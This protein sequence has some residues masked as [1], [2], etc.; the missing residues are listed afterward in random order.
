MSSGPDE[1][2]RNEL[3]VA[4]GAEQSATTSLRVRWQN[5][6]SHLHEL[7]LQ[8]QLMSVGPTANAGTNAPDTKAKPCQ[9]C[10]LPASASNEVALDHAVL[11]RESNSGVCER[12][13]AFTVFV[14]G[15]G[16]I[17]G[18]LCVERALRHV[19][20]GLELCPL[21]IVLDDRPAQALD[22][23]SYMRLAHAITPPNRL[24]NL[25]TLWRRLN[26][27][28]EA[29]YGLTSSGVPET[30]HSSN[31]CGNTT[32]S[33]W[34][35]RLPCWG[36]T[37]EG[38]LKRDRELVRARGLVRKE[39]AAV[40]AAAVGFSARVKDH[41]HAEYLRSWLKMWLWALPD[42]RRAVFIDGDM[43]VLRP[44]SVLFSRA[45]TPIHNSTV[46]AVR[47]SSCSKQRSFNSGLFVYEPSLETAKRLMSRAHGVYLRMH[48]GSWRP[49]YKACEQQVGDQ[50]L[51]NREFRNWREL[52]S[53]FNVPTRYL[54]P[55]NGEAF[56]RWIAHLGATAHIVHPAGEAKPWLASKHELNASAG[57]VLWAQSV[58]SSLLG[59]LATTTKHAP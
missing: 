34:R 46:A 55:K 6:T 59:S 38:A 48:T 32:R 43:L 26:G 12:G 19:H 11:N 58:C 35:S 15:A 22:A 10:D 16:Y 50:T 27:T 28:R 44:L 13:D 14:S 17:P 7:Q 2:T 33:G 41:H 42:V 30:G 31:L 25:T 24:V 29:V 52:N 40:A 9:G 39:Q 3:R 20:A 23:D 21:V 53:S 57:G 51:L 56:E 47:A 1:R 36:W 18:A 8:N 37:L 45:A 49:P 54:G 4:L 5:I